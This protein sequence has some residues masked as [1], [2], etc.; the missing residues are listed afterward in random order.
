MAGHEH[1]EHHEHHT[2]Q[3]AHRDEGWEDRAHDYDAVVDL[4][5]P[6][7]GK[8]SQALLRAARVAPGDRVL[9]VACGPGHTTAAATAA[10]AHATGIDASPAMIAIARARFPHTSFQES[11]MGAPPA[12]PWD[13]IICRL[14]AHHAYHAWLAA[15]HAVLRPGGRLAI[16]ETDALDAEARAKDMLSPEEWVELLRSAGFHDIQ[17]TDSGANLSTLSAEVLAEVAQRLGSDG[18]SHPEGPIYV[19]AGLRAGHH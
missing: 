1:H 13:A 3:H 14:G 2:R 11:D 18:G 16:A 5:E 17:V 6:E 12:G 4:L 19:I 10:G 9:D 7:L 8:A 15:A